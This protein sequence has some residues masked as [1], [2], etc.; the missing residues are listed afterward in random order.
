MTKSFQVQLALK[1]L[2]AAALPG[3]D[4]RG[5][6]QDTSRPTRPGPLGCVIGHWGDPGDPEVDLSP[7]AYHYSHQF[8][9]EVIGPDGAGGD[10]LDVMLAA[11]GAAIEAD[12]FLGGLCDYLDC[13]A[14]DRDDRG[15]EAASPTNWATV[16]IVADY[17]T[18]SPLG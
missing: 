11:I 1:A 10:P 14:P 18:S 16:A 13:A 4:L 12:R 2:V 6:D 8:Q 5:F 3:A 7:P 17:S 15:T 9:L